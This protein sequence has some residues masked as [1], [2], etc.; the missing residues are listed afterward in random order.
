M[1][2]AHSQLFGCGSQVTV[3]LQ[4]GSFDGPPLHLFQIGDSGGCLRLPG[5]F[6]QDI[7]GADY[8]AFT[9]DDR[10]FDGVLQLPYIARPMITA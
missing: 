4:D 6:H 7:F 8:A 3:V 10:F 9:Q 5:L 1:F 2:A